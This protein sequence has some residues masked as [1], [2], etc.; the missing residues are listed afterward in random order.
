[1]QGS[2]SRLTVSHKNNT[3]HKLPD[4]SFTEHWTM[5]TCKNI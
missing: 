4:P 5:C 1:M 3:L 2:Y